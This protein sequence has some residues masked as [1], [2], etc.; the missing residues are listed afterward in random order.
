MRVLRM[1]T[2][3]LFATCSG[4]CANA[5]AQTLALCPTCQTESQFELFGEGLA[6]AYPHGMFEF[7]V[8]NPV[9]GQSWFVTVEKER[10]YN[11][12]WTY[13]TAVRATPAQEEDFRVVW[14]LF[15]TTSETLIA[16]NQPGQGGD[17]FRTHAMEMI[18]GLIFQHPRVAA[19]TDN[20]RK[21][22]LSDQIKNMTSPPVFVIVFFN[23]D[24]AKFELVA[25]LAGY[26]AC[27][28]YVPGSA[29]DK[30]GNFINDSGLG[31]SGGSSGDPYVNRDHGTNGNNAFRV[32]VGEIWYSCAYMDGKLISC[33]RI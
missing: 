28:R 12:T 3:L 8:A 15:A 25:P 5:Q 19:A 30:D 20:P 4:L 9:T 32:R 31:G 23:G 7:E 29:R 22:K 26:S 2:Y 21:V 11:L 17:S 24:V 16:V 1:L 33:E 10:E 13:S 18:G 27:C 6:N 14:E